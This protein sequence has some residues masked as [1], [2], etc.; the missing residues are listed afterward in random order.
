MK[1]FL[2]LLALMLAVGGLA[3]IASRLGP[4]GPECINRVLSEARS[5]GGKFLATSFERTCGSQVATAVGMR[6]AEGPFIGAEADTVFVAPGRVPVRLLWRE[7]L[8]LTIESPA[9]T[10]AREESSW[11]KVQV[12]LRRLR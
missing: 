2:G 4:E 6:L 10:V 12:K 3:L 8:Q 7:E 5:P 1:L 11:R 9:R